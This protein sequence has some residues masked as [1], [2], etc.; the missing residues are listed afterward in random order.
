V[1]TSA[2]DISG[3]RLV[4]G[5]GEGGMA[6][7]YLALSRKAAGFSKL[8]VLKVLRSSTS[9]D[10]ELRRMFFDEAR[11]AALL[12]HPNV[13]QTYEAGEDEGRLFLAM[14]YLE[15]KSLSSILNARPPGDIPLDVQ[16]RIIADVLEGLHYAHE[17]T[18][19]D[20][21]PL[22]VIHRDVSPQNVLVTY[23]GVSKVVDFGIA[24]FKSS[25]NTESGVIKGKVGYMAPE[26]I[27]NSGVN[28][29]ADVYAAGVMIWEAIAKRKLVLR[30]EDEVA[31]LARRMSGAEPSVRQFAPPGTP[32]ELLA[33]CDRAMAADP[34]AR[35]QTAHDLNE[36]LDAFLKRTGGAD[37]KRVSALLESWFGEERSRIRA[38]VEQQSRSVDES[39]PLIDIARQRVVSPPSVRPSVPNLSDR[40]EAM[41]A[42]STRTAQ[43][44][45][46]GIVTPAP[47][48]KPKPPIALF[49][50]FAA[51]AV[52]GSVL[53]VASATGRR[54]PVT[55]VPASQSAPAV[56]AAAPP[57]AEPAEPASV[58][59]LEPAS[60]S[61]SA[62]ASGIAAPTKKKPTQPR[63]AIDD[64]DP[65]R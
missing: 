48:A 10:A 6:R 57:A 21:T 59:P 8:V 30:G 13:V 14:E 31:V 29:R 46:L 25:P 64:K 49:A 51:I 16:L 15:G 60:A 26:Q 40:T 37:K 44:R 41:P 27:S 34:N 43:I 65:Y 50:G 22:H 63:R 53:A 24:K 18:D 17:L 45:D 2:R 23:A 36:A 3:Y 62:S 39:S 32:E 58:T 54:K 19:V 11:I 9:E 61:A 38:L 42:Q 1:A 12:N 4:A 55:V 35:F 5:L 28:R 52:I 7:V 20:G 56:V 33:I 47:A